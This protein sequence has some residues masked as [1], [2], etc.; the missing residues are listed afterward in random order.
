MA[1]VSEAAQLQFGTK[2]GHCLRSKKYHSDL[3]GSP[4]FEDWLVEMKSKFEANADQFNINQL[5]RAYL[6]SRT[7]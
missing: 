5:K 2:L 3:D 6:V 4:N 1:C 7:A